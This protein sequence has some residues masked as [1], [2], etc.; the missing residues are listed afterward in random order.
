MKNLQYKF[1]IFFLI[2]LFLF[3]CATQEQQITKVKSDTE[4]LHSIIQE[5]Y[6]G[7]ITSG[8]EEL[9]N[10]ANETGSQG[11]A[12]DFLLKGGRRMIDDLKWFK[13]EEEQAYQKS[14]SSQD[15]AVLLESDNKMFANFMLFQI[16]VLWNVISMGNGVKIISNVPGNA[17]EFDFSAFD[18]EFSSAELNLSKFK[19]AIKSDNEA[20]CDKI[21]AEVKKNAQF[22]NNLQEIMW[23]YNE[24][25]MKS[26]CGELLAKYKSKLANDYEKLKG[27]K[28]YERAFLALKINAISLLEN[29]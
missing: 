16:D 17:E 15:I 12:N 21:F 8:E 19:S 7:L 13:T 5:Q 27:E 24:N 23:A 20:M 25:G 28:S 22:K 2:L 26:A 29:S 14:Q 11:P 6:A 18:E 1:F 10:N 3:G 9:Q 4:K